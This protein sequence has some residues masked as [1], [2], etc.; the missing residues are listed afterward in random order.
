MRRVLAAIVIVL[1]L[2]AAG[3]LWLQFGTRTVPEGQQPLTTLDL[4]SFREEFN[5]AAEATRVVVLL[6]PT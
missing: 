5:R 2:A 6:S 4:A 3:Y 1:V